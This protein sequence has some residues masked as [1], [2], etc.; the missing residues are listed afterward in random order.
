MQLGSSIAGQWCRPA[1]T[2]LIR[3]EAWELP[4][5]TGVTLKKTKDKK[6]KLFFVEYLK[7]FIICGIFCNFQIYSRVFQLYMYIFFPDSFPFTVITK[8]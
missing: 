4:Y 2:V 3:P 1:A 7:V 6:K 5:A 8:Y